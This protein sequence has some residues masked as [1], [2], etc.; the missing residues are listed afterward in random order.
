VGRAVTFA[1]KIKGHQADRGAAR[2]DGEDYWSTCKRCGTV[3]IRG[4]QGWREATGDEV[5]AH[6][7]N[8]DGKAALDMSAGLSRTDGDP[9]PD[10]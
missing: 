9:A 3:L 4:Q 5:A 7:H 10:A 8:V 2:H 1:C 6:R